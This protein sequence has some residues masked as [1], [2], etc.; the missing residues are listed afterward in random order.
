MLNEIGIFVTARL[1]LILLPVHN[2]L[3]EKGCEDLI[4]AVQVGVRDV[5]LNL[6]KVLTRYEIHRK[7]V[8]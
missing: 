4:E 8:R 7:S 1:L 6:S 2:H 3:R 5:K